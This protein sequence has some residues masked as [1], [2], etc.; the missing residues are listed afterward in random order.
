MQYINY[1]DINIHPSNGQDPEEY[2]KERM[3]LSGL[4]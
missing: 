3:A 4:L 2:L 1:A